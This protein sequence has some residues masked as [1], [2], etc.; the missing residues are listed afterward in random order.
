MWWVWAVILA[1]SL[2]AVVG[3]SRAGSVIFWKAHQE[4]GPNTEQE[5]DEEAPTPTS[6]TLPLA[7][8]GALL[9]LLIVMTAASG[10]VMRELEATAD[11]LFAPEP[12]IE[13]VLT[14]KGK[15]IAYDGDKA[16]EH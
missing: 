9:V 7:S 4:R 10:P 3:F 11:Q 8:I 1:G 2:V 13:T 14:T 15:V 6:P 5:T 16:E 12:Y